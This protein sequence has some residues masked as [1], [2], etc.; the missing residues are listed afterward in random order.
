MEIDK[1]TLM[2]PIKNLDRRMYDLVR[3]FYLA[4]N[5]YEAKVIVFAEILNSV[6]IVDCRG[7][8]NPDEIDIC[9]HD[10]VHFACVIKGIKPVAYIYDTSLEPFMTTY[11]NDLQSINI[12]QVL[13]NKFI[14]YHSDNKI[15]AEIFKN[16]VE[17]V[18]VNNS[19]TRS[20][21]KAKFHYILG[22]CLGYPKADTD[23][24]VFRN[25]T[26]DINSYIRRL[27]G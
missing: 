9:A 1:L 16:F 21:F 19:I 13:P 18:N 22:Y 2:H 11:K 7:A 25:Q 4:A 24:F 26:V 12:D 6:T 17:G 14:V 8:V 23:Y 10:I 20:E 3:K 15:K 5:T 27:E